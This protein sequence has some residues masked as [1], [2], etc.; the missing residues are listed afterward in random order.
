MLQ[1]GSGQGN[2]NDFM[3]GQANRNS[4]GKNRK[5]CDYCKKRGHMRVSETLLSCNNF[6]KFAAG[7]YFSG[8]FLIVT[9]F[10]FT[11]ILFAS[12][13]VISFVIKITHIAIIKA[14]IHIVTTIVGIAGITITKMAML[15]IS[16]ILAETTRSTDNFCALKSN[17]C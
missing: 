15:I 4:N 7:W 5:F 2:G 11:T 3:G 10:A 14:I 12:L 9:S 17:L 8:T 16:G 1:N 6:Q 13:N